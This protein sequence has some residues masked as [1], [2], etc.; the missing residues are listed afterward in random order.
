[1]KPQTSYVAKPIH[2]RRRNLISA[3]ESRYLIRLTPRRLLFANLLRRLKRGY[4]SGVHTVLPAS[5]IRS[6]SHVSA[7]T[8]GKQFK[9]GDATFSFEAASDRESPTSALPRSSPGSSE[10]FL[11]GATS[12]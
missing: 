3:Y 6:Q 10:A 1:M 5:R 12:L 2:A 4:D 8:P 11:K 9:L 7:A